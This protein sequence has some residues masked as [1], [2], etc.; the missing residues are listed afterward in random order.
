MLL[1]LSI[2]LLLLSLLLL[3][4]VLLLL[5]FPLFPPTLSG[6][7]CNDPDA[8]SPSA[9]PIFFDSSVIFIFQN[10]EVG[11][12][13]DESEE[14]FVIVD[15]ADSPGVAKDFSMSVSAC[16]EATSYANIRSFGGRNCCVDDLSSCCCSIESACVDSTSTSVFC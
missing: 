9:D 2:L 13:E 5:L 1:L 15:D 10:L 3:L 14:L 7:F 6:L 16:A 4:F 8:D 12:S 11:E